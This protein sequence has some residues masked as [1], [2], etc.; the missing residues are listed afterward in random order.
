VKKAS[1]ITG[2]GNKIVNFYIIL[3]CDKVLLLVIRLA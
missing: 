1:I 2:V 3:Y